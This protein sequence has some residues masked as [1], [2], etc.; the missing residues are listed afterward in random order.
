MLKIGIFFHE[1]KEKI[2]TDITKGG[3]ANFLF[4]SANPQ[5]LG[6]IPLSQIR[7][8]NFLDVQV[9]KS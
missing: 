5:T 1:E 8:Q 2:N 6:L 3:R 7:K 4:N 9:R